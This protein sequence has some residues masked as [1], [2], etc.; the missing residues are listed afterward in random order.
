MIVLFSFFGYASWA[1]IAGWLVGRLAG[2]PVRMVGWLTICLVG[3]W[4]VGL[5]GWQSGWLPRWFCTQPVA[6]R[7]PGRQ[8]VRTSPPSDQPDRQAALRF[9]S[10]WAGGPGRVGSDRAGPGWVV[11]GTPC[12]WRPPADCIGHRHFLPSFSVPPS[13]SPLCHA[14]CRRRPG[15][16]REARDFAPSFLP[17]AWCL[18]A[19]FTIFRGTAK[20]RAGYLH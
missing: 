11:S 2:W 7:C 17:S 4:L 16:G 15:T 18:L 20:F 12:L 1:W 6:P 14:H 8:C 19:R 3:C 10:W 9:P 13:V 5:A